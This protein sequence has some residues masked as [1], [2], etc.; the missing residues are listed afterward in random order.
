MFIVI[1]CQYVPSIFWI[2]LSK[3]IMWTNANGQNQDKWDI[4]YKLDS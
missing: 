1:V 3:F 4:D 2:S